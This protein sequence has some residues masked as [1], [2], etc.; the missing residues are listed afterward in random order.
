MFLAIMVLPRPL[1]PMSARLRPSRTNSRVRARSMRSR[2][3]FLGQFQSKSAMGLRRPMRALRS[4]LSWLRRL[5][6]ISSSRAISSRICTGDRRLL[7]ARARK[8]SRERPIACRPTLSRRLARSVAFVIVAARE[9]I[10]GLRG[11]RFDV[12]VLEI[13][14]AR[15]VDRQTHPSLRR[16]PAFGED[17]RDGAD[18]RGLPGEGLLHGRAELFGS[19]VVEKQQQLLGDAGDRLAPPEACLDKSLRRRDGAYEPGI[20]SGPLR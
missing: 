19:V 8:S 3:I 10:V 20:G 5:L 12:E 2:S 4:R 1:V 16:S 9:F 17:E 7:V 15:E 6:S 18:A 13:G 14:P 11:M